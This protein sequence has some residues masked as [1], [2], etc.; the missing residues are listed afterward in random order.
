[1]TS[2]VWAEDESFFVVHF[3]ETNQVKVFARQTSDIYN[4]MIQK[5]QEIACYQ[6]QFDRSYITSL[7]SHLISGRENQ[8]CFKLVD[9]VNL[10]YDFEGTNSKHYQ[11]YCLHKLTKVCY[12]ER[13]M[14]F[15]IVAEYVAHDKFK[16]ILY[17]LS[18]SKRKV[19][20]NFHF[21]NVIAPGS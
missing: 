13:A 1:M 6:P 10:K 12:N 17:N 18:F 3:S 16:Y 9:S 4:S 19:E 15:E 20:A 2:C 7:I 21:E 8:V 14:T 11:T 5:E